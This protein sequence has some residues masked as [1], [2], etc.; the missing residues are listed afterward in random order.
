[1]SVEVA[2]QSHQPNLGHGSN[3]DGKHCSKWNQ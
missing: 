1:M 3:R 2:R